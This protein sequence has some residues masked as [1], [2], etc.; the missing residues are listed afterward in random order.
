MFYYTVVQVMFRQDCKE[1]KTACFPYKVEKIQCSLC[2][3]TDCQCTE[4]EL[5]EKQ[6][7]VDPSKPHLASLCHKCRA[8]KPC[9][10]SY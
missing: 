10:S 8:G 4:E 9:R 5:E 3:L 1:C 6:R 7:H 2:G